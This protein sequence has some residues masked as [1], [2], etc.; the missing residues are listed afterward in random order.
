MSERIAAADLFGAD[1]LADEPPAAPAR[2][3]K[4]RA[5]RLLIADGEGFLTRE[6]G[7]IAIELDGLPG[8]RHR[9]HARP[10]CS[11]VPWYP[12]GAPIRNTRQVSLVAPDELGE[13]ARRL[14]IAEVKPEWLGANLVVEGVRRLTRLPP[15]TRLHFPDG[16]ALAVEGENGPCRHAGAAIGANYPEREGLDLAFPKVARGL[17]GL[18][19]WVERAGEI[20][21]GAEIEVRVPAQYVWRS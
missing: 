16:A 10:A 11:R 3:F 20:A 21:S 19:A 4:A 1:P 17:R 13:I 12:R 2:R 18:V 15:G 5:A 14:G 6:I 7:R 8:D 9:G